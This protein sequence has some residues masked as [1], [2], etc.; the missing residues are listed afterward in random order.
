MSQDLREE[1]IAS[2]SAL[3]MCA[4]SAPLRP[5]SCR[6]TATSPGATS[7]G[8]SST[9]LRIAGGSTSPATPSASSSRPFSSSGRSSRYDVHEPADL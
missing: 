9:R 8:A 7:S 1:R 4:A 6:A 5:S 2:D 3:F